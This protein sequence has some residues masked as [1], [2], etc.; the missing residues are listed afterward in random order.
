MAVDQIITVDGKLAV[1]ADGTVA[2]FESEAEWEKL[3]CCPDSLCPSDTDCL[4]CL[5]DNT[6]DA[7]TVTITGVDAGACGCL[8]HAS[9]PT[10]SLGNINLSVDGQYLLGQTENPCQW[11]GSGGSYSYRHYTTAGN[12]T[13][14]YDTVSGTCDFILEKGGILGQEWFWRIECGAAVY[15][16]AYAMVERAAALMDTECCTVVPNIAETGPCHFGPSSHLIST[17]GVATFEEC[18]QT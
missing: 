4:Q 2:L 1:N 16:Y 7:Y 15:F 8:T 5:D 12:C 9:S 6:P 11:R 14:V 13:G 10:H 3:C 18:D 17:G